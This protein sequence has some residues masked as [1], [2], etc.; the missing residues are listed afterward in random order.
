MVTFRW[1]MVATADGS[2]AGGG[3]EVL[4]LASDGR[5]RAGYQLIDG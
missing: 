4:L 2:V 1:L 3:R 5:I